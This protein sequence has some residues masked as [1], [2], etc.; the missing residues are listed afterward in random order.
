[1]LSSIHKHTC[2]DNIKL[3]AGRLNCNSLMPPS[4]TPAHILRRFKLHTN[5]TNQQIIKSLHYAYAYNMMILAYSETSLQNTVQLTYTS[6]RKLW[7][8]ILS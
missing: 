7:Y 8:S 5:L 2:A 4:H 6:F 3:P 1:M